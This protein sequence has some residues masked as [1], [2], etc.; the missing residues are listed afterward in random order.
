M[1]EA[2]VL[3]FILGIAFGSFVSINIWIIIASILCSAI[4]FL[5]KFIVPENDRRVIIFSSLIIL[6]LT[7]GLV[8]MFYSDLNQVSK[9]VSLADKKIEVVGIVS[10]EPDLR[11]KNTKLT[12]TLQEAKVDTMVSKI[13]EKI[14]VTVPTYPEYQY[15]DKVKLDLILTQP[16]NI[17]SDDGRVFDYGG[18][19][20]VRGIW[21]TSSFAKVE[22]LSSGNG[23]LIKSTL[24]RTKKLFTHS[25]NNALPEPESSLM[26]G[27]LLGTKQSLG[28]DL[29]Q[30]FQRSGVSHLVVLSGYNIAIVAESIMGL[31]SFLPKTISFGFGVIGIILFTILSGG[32]ASAWRAAIMVLVALSAK[33]LNREYKASR[34]LGFAVVLMLAPNPLLLIFDPSFQL[35]ILATIGIVFVSPII[36]PFFSKVT[37]KYGLREV[38]SSTI[39]TQIVVLPFLIYNTGLVSIV[40]LPVNI[41]VLGTVPAT[42]LFG[43]LT[44]L[45]GL[46]SLYLSFVPA[47][48]AYVL[49]WY[50]LTIIHLGSVMPFGTIK[51]PAFGPGV[52]VIL[53]A[54]IFITLIY[55]NNKNKIIKHS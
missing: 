5:Y 32:G 54:V 10:E 14:L 23:S 41:L 17:E 37:E 18:Y 20:R 9:L 45:F 31:L 19:L 15:G 47:I 26:A 8:R 28:K 30:E 12:I 29:L 44:G 38:V 39:A 53:Y 46:V 51:L 1:I 6:G 7:I 25:I 40:S 49:L 21:Y 3:G 16:K 11:E 2:I 34:A 36:E 27:L 24:F 43:S 42:M 33:K 50:Q 52:L 48:F 35:S 4:L 22:L 55:I 13:T